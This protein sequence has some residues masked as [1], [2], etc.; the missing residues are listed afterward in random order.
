MT[1]WEQE[2]LRQLEQGTVGRIYHA[3]LRS[4]LDRQEPDGY[5][6]ESLSGAYEGEYCRTIGALTEL[7]L[8]L[9]EY[10]RARSALEFV[11]SC[12]EQNEL[13]RVPH[14][15]GRRPADGSGQW[16]SREDQIDGRAHVVMA[17]ARYCL[18]A[19]D[20]E[21]V[22]HHYRAA[23]TEV[24]AFL[25]QPYFYYQPD[26][27]QW[28][29][30]GLQLVFNASFEH[31]REHRRW[32]A[33]DLLSQCFVGAAGEAMVRLARRVHDNAFAD[34]AARRLELLQ[35]GVARRL[36]RTVDG[37]TV[38]LEMLLPDGDWG[39]PFS[40]MGWVNLSPLAAGWSG[41]DPQWLD[42]TVEL[43]HRRLR[44]DDPCGSGFAV[45]MME[46]DGAGRPVFEIMGKSMAWDMEYDRRTGSWEQLAQWFGF[47]QAHHGDGDI[48]MEDMKFDGVRWQKADCGNGEQCCWWC[49]AVARLYRTLTGK[50]AAEWKGSGNC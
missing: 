47:L 5:F 22:A 50:S 15:L 33:F 16:I 18:S 40:G 46:D 48:L 39:V 43:L 37:K 2:L 49:W 42:Q 29:C 14:V 44:V 38:Y 1:Q 45:T 24:E 30:T 11:F 20:W 9:G 23:R 28:A 17:F 19:G 41:L 7:Y 8:E 27:S 10:R 12:M 31:S 4:I 35:A 25:E 13:A 26:R 3:T 6:A 34:W 36:T 32:A 21:F